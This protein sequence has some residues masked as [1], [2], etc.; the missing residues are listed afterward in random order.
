MSKKKPLASRGAVTRGKP[1]ARK[2]PKTKKPA[3]KSGG[4]ARGAP[5]LGR[6]KVT[7]DELLYMLFKEDYHARQIFEF[8]KVNTVREL[9][10][11]T[12]SEIFKRLSQPVRDAVERIRRT[13]AQYNR[14]LPGDKEY[15]LEIRQES[16]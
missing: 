15:A 3:V 1:A 14:C 4:R 10:Q 8:L 5:S 2:A 13:L 11:H 12:A 6:P 16:S 9:E 7:G